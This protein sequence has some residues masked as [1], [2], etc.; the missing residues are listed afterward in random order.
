MVGMSYSEVRADQINERTL[1]RPARAHS[2]V[3][4]PSGLDDIMKGLHLFAK[5][6][7]AIDLELNEI[8]LSPRWACHS[9]NGGLSVSSQSAKNRTV[10]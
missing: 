7:F 4:Y 10:S 5:V 9:R 3:A 8:V 1:V 2:D 6:S